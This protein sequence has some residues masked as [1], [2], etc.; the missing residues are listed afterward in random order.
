MIRSGLLAFAIAASA[1]VASSAGA[2]P[3]PENGDGRYT[4]H[5]AGDG[6]VRLDERTGQVSMCNRRPSG[7]QCNLL[8]DERTALEAEIA[9][10]QADNAALKKEL[11]SRNLALPS[12]IRPDPPAP[13]PDAQRPPSRDEAEVNRVVN[14]FEKVWRRLVEMIASVQRDLL[15]RT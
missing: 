2:Q 6:Y 12:G 3:P 4:F 10:L 8:P 14:L 15:K 13:G 7:W 9:R 5:R 11:L 1:L